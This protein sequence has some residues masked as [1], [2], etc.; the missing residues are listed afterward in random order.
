MIDF[1]EI[2]GVYF[3]G[4][5]GIGMSALAE[6]FAGNGVAVAGYDRTSSAI[7]DSLANEGCNISFIDDISTIPDN[8]KINNGKVLVVFTPAI[9]AEN[10][11]ITFFRQAEFPIC[12]RSEVLGVISRG[13]DTVAIS[14]THGKTTVSTMTAHI[15]KQSK[16][17][18]S[19][20]LG[21]ISK[22]YGSNLI[23]GNSRFT[24][25]EADEFD[26]SFHRLTPLYAVVTAT[27]ADHLDIYG[28]EEN[29]IEG[30]S[31]FIEKIRQE[32]AVILNYK[33]KDKVRIPAGLKYFTYGFDSA[34]DYHCGNIKFE[35]GTYRF[36]ISTPEGVIKDI[37]FNFPGITNVENF[38]AATSLALQCGVDEQDIK[39]AAASFAGVKRRFDIRINKAGLTYVDDYAHHPEEIKSCINSLLGYFGDRKITG[40]FQPHLFSRTL[41]HYEGF[42]KVLD[43]LDEVI[44][45]PIY[46]AREKPVP[47]VTSKLILDKMELKNKRLLDKKEDLIDAIDASKIDVLVTIGA[48]DID[49]LVAPLEEKLKRER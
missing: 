4:I 28:T 34:A 38:T 15:L 37:V 49:T 33:I 48:G 14:G 30:Y 13:T 43:Q 26:R 5:G 7:T 40:V 46:P 11:I 42:A 25:M 18:C 22:N 19:A 27:D 9:P 23:R 3:V 36:D 16:L 47:G 21:G 6:Y 10:K 17:D 12:K 8:F 39:N 45:L 1:K 41:D 24:V 44:L 29:M 35:D 32:G 31:V 2:E 20:F